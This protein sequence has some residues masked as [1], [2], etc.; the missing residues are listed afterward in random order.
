[1]LLIFWYF[2][3]FKYTYN[4]NSWTLDKTCE[5]GKTEYSERTTT[6]TI[7]FNLFSFTKVHIQ[8][9]IGKNLFSSMLKCLMLC[10]LVPMLKIVNRSVTI[11][12]SS[13]SLSSPWMFFWM[14]RVRPSRH[15]NLSIFEVICL[16]NKRVF[17]C[18]FDFYSLLFWLKYVHLFV[19]YF[20]L[21][22][23]LFGK[24]QSEG[25]D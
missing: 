8:T 1:M 6:H 12:F 7:L 3:F 10:C 2:R 16:W 18:R 20:V 17:L 11:L 9:K 24:Y 21:W 22:L 19:G 14:K 5:V 23:V 13:I 15:S 4:R 25:S